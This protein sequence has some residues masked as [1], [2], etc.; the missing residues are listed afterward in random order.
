VLDGGIRAVNFFTSR[1]LT[2]SDFNREQTR[3]A[4]ATHGWARARQWHRQR[5]EVELAPDKSTGP[6][7]PVVRVRR[8]SGQ[9]LRA[10]RLKDDASSR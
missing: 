9:P 5:L 10:L 2:G 6:S 1:L 4:A 7:R 8:R 3:G